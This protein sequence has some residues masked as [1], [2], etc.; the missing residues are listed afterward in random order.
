MKKK[1]EYFTVQINN[2]KIVTVDIIFTYDELN[3]IRNTKNTKENVTKKF[4]SFIILIVK[5]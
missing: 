1:L 3:R 2:L 4:L 5:R